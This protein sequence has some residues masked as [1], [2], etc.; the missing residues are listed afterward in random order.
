MS[1]R[2]TRETQGLLKEAADVNRE[3]TKTNGEL[4][5]DNLFIHLHGFCTSMA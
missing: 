4:D 3:S 2:K 1:A 5:V